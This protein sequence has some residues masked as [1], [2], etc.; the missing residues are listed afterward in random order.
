M[1]DTVVALSSVTSDGNVYFAKNSDREP[2]EAQVLELVP[3]GRHGVGSQVK[4]TYISIPQVE[5]TNT[6]LLSKPFWMWGAEMGVNEHG[7]AI[8]NEALFTRIKPSKES[9][10][11]GMDLLRLAL[12]RSRNSD[13]ALHIL[14]DLIVNYGQSGNCSFEHQLFYHNS[15][16]IADRENAWV[17]ETADK[18][19]AALKVK[20]YYSI[21]NGI[22]IEKDWDLASDDLVKYAIDNKWCRS[23]SEFSFKRC[24]S[25]FLYTNFSQSSKRRCD[26]FEYLKRNVRHMD[27]QSLI[28]LLRLHDPEGNSWR[29]DRSLTEWTVCVHKGFGPIRA[30]Q[31]TGS[32]VSRLSLE[33]DLHF[34]T[35]TSAPCTSLFKPVWL[36]LAL[37][38]IGEP[39][40]KNKYDERTMWW[41]HE[42]V[43]RKMLEN[44]GDYHAAYQVERNQIEEELISKSMEAIAGPTSIRQKIENEGFTSSETLDNKF[45]DEFKS[46][47]SP[48]D[49]FLLH[50]IEWK[51]HNLKAGF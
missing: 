17:L 8:G 42:R 29:P 13:E 44:F 30:S 43:H 38:N 4:C 21:S 31:T 37:P 10:L 24:Y 49:Q 41:R 9:G 12:E 40:P 15:F 11:I 27:F 20:D 23:E 3:G 33:G 50:R 2:N 5:Q 48:D 16:L 14:I 19:W 47:P 36:D 32:M 39:H 28:N 51:G 26:T 18:H 35:G 34:L 22:T 46:N 7:V 6:V 1:C 25:D 45:M